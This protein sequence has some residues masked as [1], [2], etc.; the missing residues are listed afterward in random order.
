MDYIIFDPQQELFSCIKIALE[1]K[2]Y[3]VY[4]GVL[5][6]KGTAYPFFYLGEV[7]QTDNILKNGIIT[8]SVY[9]TI[10]AWH[11]NPRQRGV[12]SSM[13]ADAKRTCMELEHTAN[14]SWMIGGTNQQ[15]F[16]DNTTEAPLLHGVLDV[17]YQYC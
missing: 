4:D 9:Q 16:Q 10:H 8:G 11:N 2:G 12:V 6:P 1:K 15:I 17:T 3:A 13:L 5:P 14:Y 7:Q